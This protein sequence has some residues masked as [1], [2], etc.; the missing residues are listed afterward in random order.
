MSGDDPNEVFCPFSALLKKLTGWSKPHPAPIVLVFPSNSAPNQVMGLFSFNSPLQQ[1][2]HLQM[3]A[4]KVDESFGIFADAV[5][6]CNSRCGV[7]SPVRFS[8]K[9]ILT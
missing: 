5:H 3:Q 2:L 8:L 7:F 9:N 4:E 6:S 1:S